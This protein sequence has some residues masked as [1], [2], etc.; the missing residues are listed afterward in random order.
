MGGRAD[1]DAPRRPP[2]TTRAD[3]HDARSRTIRGEL[4]PLLVA[5]AAPSSAAAEQYRALRTRIVNGDRA[6]ADRLLLVTSAGREEGRSVTAANLGLTFAHSDQRRVCVVDA[7]LR[8]P[9]QDRLFGV[10][11][12]PGLSDVLTNRAALEDALLVVEGHG[13]S[14]L[15]A[16]AAPPNPAELL[17]SPAM[18]RVMHTLRSQFDS[19]VVDAPAA[20]P[21]ADV[22]ILTSLVDT[23]MLVAR[24]GTTSQP[25]LRDAIAAIDSTKLIGVVLNDAR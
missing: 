9:R 4:D 7:D 20:T 25:A 13:V 12:G 17:G 8:S 14:V 21:L 15:T 10:A 1:A 24:A 11:G 3:T 5:G 22:G 16:G 19:I 18:R 23:V 6:G 2:A